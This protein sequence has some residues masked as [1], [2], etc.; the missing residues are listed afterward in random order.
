MAEK[1][2]NILTLGLSLGI[3]AAFAAGILAF[4]NNFTEKAREKTKSEKTNNALRMVLPEFDN[5]PGDNILIK[6]LKDR[7]VTFFPAIKN[8]NLV[9]IAAS[10]A[11]PEGY[12]GKLS[13]MIGM[14]ADGKIRT[15]IVTENNET[16]GLGTTVTDRK[17]EK[18]IFDIFAENKKKS[19]IKIPANKVLDSFENRYISSAPWKVKKDGGDIEAITGA[20]ISSRAVTDAVNAIAEGFTTYKDEILKNFSSEE[21]IME[22]RN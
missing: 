7:E 8:N 12:G 14:Y 22:K 17:S 1:K 19:D 21:K 11:T 9:G 6:K 13:L 15:V 5:N 20:T 2:E 10:T 4:T 18:T 3:I 16:P